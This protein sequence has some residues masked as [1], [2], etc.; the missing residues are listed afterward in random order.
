MATV[1]SLPQKANDC[2]SSSHAWGWIFRMFAICC[3]PIGRVFSR[4]QK[5][6]TIPVIHEQVT[7]SPEGAEIWK[8][9]EDDPSSTVGRPIGHQ[10]RR[11]E[12]G[13]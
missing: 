3:R 1:H 6:R 5:R 12:C 10:R 7:L 2:E 11:I 13:D 9:V 8:Q 4:T